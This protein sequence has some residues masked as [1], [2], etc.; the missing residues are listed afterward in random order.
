M[1]KN[2]ACNPKIIA[3]TLD[4]R[5]P[6]IVSLCRDKKEKH[7]YTMKKMTFSAPQNDALQYIHCQGQ[8]TG[9]HQPW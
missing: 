8:Y 4:N 9:Y 7:R 1:K 3:G 5:Y 2:F 6:E